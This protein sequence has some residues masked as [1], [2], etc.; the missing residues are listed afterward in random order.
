MASSLPIPAPPRTPTPPT[1]ILGDNASGLNINGL[2]QT[3]NS[4]VSYDPNALSPLTGTFPGRFGSMDSTLPS[5]ATTSSTSTNSDGTLTLP[6][7]KSPFNFQTQIYSASPAVTKS[8]S[9]LMALIEDRLLI[10][11]EYGAAAGTQI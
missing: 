4:T 6:T 2:P 8:V 11:T 1:P 10:L 7:S 5:P 9:Q 3:V